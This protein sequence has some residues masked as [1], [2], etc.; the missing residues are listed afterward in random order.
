MYDFLEVCNIFKKEFATKPVYNQQYL[1]YPKTKI[2]IYTD[3]QC[4]CLSVILFN[5]V[6]TI[7]KDYYTQVFLEKCKYVIKEKKTIFLIT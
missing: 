2:K 5:S 7:H 4:I 6:V 1:K 3:L